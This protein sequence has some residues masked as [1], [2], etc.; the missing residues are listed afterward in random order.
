MLCGSAEIVTHLEEKLDIKMGE[1]TADG[2][3]S[4]KEV[5]CLGACVGAPMFQI[6]TQ[7]YENLTAE[8]VDGIL[9]ELKNGESS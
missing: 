8:K 7:Y 6:G 4:L 3:F 5:E 1:V 2:F 9:D